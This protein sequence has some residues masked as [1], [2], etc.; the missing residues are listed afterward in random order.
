MLLNEEKMEILRSLLSQM[1]DQIDEVTFAEQIR[2]YLLSDTKNGKLYKY[3]RINKYSLSDLEN[4][5]L[6]ASKP[7]IFNDPFDSRIVL[8]L[9]SLCE[10]KYDLKLDK[11][12]EIFS[13]FMEVYSRRKKLEDCSTEIREDVRKLLNN[14]RLCNFIKEYRG[15]DLSKQEK[16]D[17][18]SRNMDVLD[19]VS[20]AILGNDEARKELAGTSSIAH[21]LIER[22]PPEKLIELYQ[23]PESYKD[24]ARAVGVEEDGDEI[25]LMKSIYQLLYPN[26]S[27]R[28]IRMDKIFS[29]LDRQLRYP[30]DDTFHVVSLSTEYDN[31]LMWAHYANDH[32]G[33]CIEYDFNTVK[34]SDICS[35]VFPVVYSRIRPKYLWRAAFSAKSQDEKAAFEALML[36]L[37]T[38][39]D[40]WSYERE[41]R[42]LV[43]A[44]R[45]GSEISAPPISC[46]YLGALCNTRNKN[47]VLA[48]AK[49]LRIPVKQ[50]VIDRGEYLLHAQPI[51]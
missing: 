36:S 33:F 38:K 44:G 34:G 41:W 15:M 19:I 18:L 11:S 25:T 9:H 2:A 26:D 43:S 49:K 23:N 48:I 50:M 6:H 7:S 5:T 20:S 47:R 22:I 1:H 13:E 30:I 40:V 31:R 4:Q 8:E 17:L 29:D 46:I 51:P 3:R 32:K 39:D 24:L 12:D 10:A 21:A 16:L 45:H 28:M 35:C 27:K 37:L 14:E 42:I